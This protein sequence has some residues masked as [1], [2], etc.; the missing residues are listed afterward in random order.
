MVK[1]GTKS[2][3]RARRGRALAQKI[4]ALA[5]QL[6]RDV[7]ILDV[8]G[9]RDYW[10]NVGFDCIGKITLLNIDPTDLERD[11]ARED[12]FSDTIGDACKLDNIP[13]RSVDF[14]HS[15]SVI[16]HVGDWSQMKSMAREARRV[17]KH[18]WLQTPAWE[19]PIEPHFKLPFMHWMAT[20]ARASLLWFAKG[21]RDQDHAERRAHA[22]RI[23]LLSK[24]EVK[25][26]FPDSALDIERVVFAKSYVVTW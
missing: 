11:T 9:R 24:G 16:E 8:G 5:G 26:L 6:G 19:F 12:L 21:Y 15:N 4:T 18:G 23:N 2:Y 14:Y 17:A 10:D 1:D 20:P 7:N 13:D 22:E 3:F 25:I